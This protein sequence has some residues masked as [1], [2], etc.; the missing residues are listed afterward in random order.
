MAPSDFHLV[1][2][3]EQFLGGMYM[4][5]DEEVKKTIKDWFSGLVQ[6]STIQTYKNSSHDMAS[7]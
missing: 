5:S 1:T 4:G 2:H 7:A 3:L 6:I